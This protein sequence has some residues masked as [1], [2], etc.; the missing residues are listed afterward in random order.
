M[1]DHKLFMLNMRHK[2]RQ[3]HKTGSGIFSAILTKI[4]EP[5]AML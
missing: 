5:K 2:R 1:K 3:F 4:S